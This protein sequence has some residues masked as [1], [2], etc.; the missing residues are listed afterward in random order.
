[1]KIISALAAVAALALAAAPSALATTKSAR[2]GNVKATLTYSGRYPNFGAERLTIRRAGKVY[3]SQPVVGPVCGR[4]CDPVA[5]GFADLEAPRQSDVVVELFTG[6]AHCCTIAQVFAYDPGTM[7][8]TKRQHD[9][10]DPGYRLSG[11]THNGVDE[12]VTADDSFAYEFTDFAASGLPIQILS[13]STGR[14]RNVTRSYPTLVANDAATWLK[15]FDGMAKQHYSDSVG[16]IA[17]WAADEDLLGNSQTV[18]T[19]LSQQ[20]QEGHLKS[21]LNP[22][23]SGQAFITALDTFLR[24]HGYL[25]G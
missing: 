11:L 13:F 20:A 17:A 15:A 23:E 25:T 6:G 1:M 21:A 12:F 10:G 8:Y 3:Y 18:A 2:S 9:F 19:F 14:F 16:V 7:T 4:H 5:V 22:K 24:K